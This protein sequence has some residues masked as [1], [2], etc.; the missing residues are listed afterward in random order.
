MM[1][2]KESLKQLK[3]IKNNQKNNVSTTE[4][5]INS[6]SSAILLTTAV[7]P[8]QHKDSCEKIF[9]GADIRGL[10]FSNCDLT[11]FDFSNAVAGVTDFYKFSLVILSMLVSL[12]FLFIMEYAAQRTSLQF[13]TQVSSDHAD[14]TIINLTVGLYTLVMFIVPVIGTIFKKGLIQTIFY[15]FAV[16]FFGVCIA[17]SYCLLLVFA[18]VITRNSLGSS[19]TLLSAVFQR[20]VTSGITG[21]VMILSSVVISISCTVVKIIQNKQIYDSFLITV[22][23]AAVVMSLIAFT[24]YHEISKIITLTFGVAEIWCASNMLKESLINNKYKSIKDISIE[25]VAFRGTKFENSILSY[26]SFSEASLKF[27][28]FKQSRKDHENLI[29]TNWINSKELDYALL[30]NTILENEAVRKLLVC[31]YNS[32][33]KTF[34]NCDLTGAYLSEADLRNMNFTDSNF[35]DALLSRANLENTKLIRT[36]L[37]GSILS[38][39][40]LTGAYGISTLNINNATKF[41]GVRGDFVYLLDSDMDRYPVS[42]EVT[43]REGELEKYLKKEFNTVDFLYPNG[44]NTRAFIEAI[45][46]YKVFDK[47]N[48]DSEIS[49]YSVT[50]KGDGTILIK[51]N[52]PASKDK[53]EFHYKMLQYYEERCTIFHDHYAS[54]YQIKET[55]KDLLEK[56]LNA[57]SIE[58]VLNNYGYI[59]NVVGVSNSN[60]TQT[61]IGL[62]EGNIFSVQDTARL[63]T[64]VR[65]LLDSISQVKNDSSLSDDLVNQMVVVEVN[66]GRG[67]KERLRSA[68]NYGGVELVKAIFSHPI[69]S[70]SIETIR[71]FIEAD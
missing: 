49:I 15:T 24:G 13:I 27:T 34:T 2:Q 5:K 23:A 3:K 50:N 4:S 33:N 30:N 43:L 20:T 6:D 37:V 10:D 69:I 42:R 63:A 70:I 67:L 45:S 1:K 28:N 25:I 41:G 66:N 26:A 40:N 52:I 31:P 17:I 32:Q 46:K 38:Q 54:L 16:G 29:Q 39:A 18:T 62:R 35:T 59:G 53:E 14:E 36:T 12:I 56:L 7:L 71:G 51:V 61:A 22:Y 9:V 11:G 8:L 58:Q 21:V 65:A 57:R 64:D 47:D 48:E 19:T 55:E 44:V 60:H 68:I